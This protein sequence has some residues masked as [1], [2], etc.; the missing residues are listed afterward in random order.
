MSDIETEIVDPDAPLKF[1]R[2]VVDGEEAAMIPWG[3]AQAIAR[4]VAGHKGEN[5]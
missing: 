5:E 1:V 4:A 2:L 3:E